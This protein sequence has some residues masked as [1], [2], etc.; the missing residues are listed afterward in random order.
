M[1]KLARTKCAD[2]LCFQTDTE[3]DAS[4]NSDFEYI[5]SFDREALNDLKVKLF[6][7]YSQYTYSKRKIFERVFLMKMSK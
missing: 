3:F 4:D 2:Y 5:C 6:M 7:L 1:Q